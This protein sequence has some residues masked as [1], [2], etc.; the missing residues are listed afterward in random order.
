MAGFFSTGHKLC[1]AVRSTVGV[2]LAQRWVV[3]GVALKQWEVVNAVMEVCLAVGLVA[4][5]WSVGGMVPDW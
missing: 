1:V 4:E 3:G 2:E 5:R